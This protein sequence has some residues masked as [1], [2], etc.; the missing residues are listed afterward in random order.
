MNSNYMK[1]IKREW[2]YSSEILRKTDIY[3]YIYIYIDR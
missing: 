1:K 3:I 2:L